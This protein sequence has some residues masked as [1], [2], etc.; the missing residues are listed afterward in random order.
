M[1]RLPALTLIVCTAAAVAAQ[2]PEPAF[3]VASIK[4]NKSGAPSRFLQP[5]PGGR[6]NV[7]NM[8]LRN[9]IAFAYQ[10]RTFQI[11]GGP[12]WQ[13]RIAFDITAKAPGEV[14]APTGAPMTGYTA[15]LR[16]L[17]AER[18][19]LVVRRT[20]KEAPIY[21]LTLAR[22]DGRLGPRLAPSA[23]DCQAVMKEALARG[24]G[25]PPMDPSRFCGA[26]IGVGR[27]ELGGFPIRDLAT[28]LSLALQRTVVDRTG[29]TG[30]FDATVTFAAE[31]LPGVPPMAA[32]QAAPADPD[33]PSLFTALQEQLGLK[34]ES[35]RGPV[36]MLV[37]ERVEMPTED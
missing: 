16:T 8:P 18:F 3:E 12:D 17:L 9:L 37:I 6:L 7:S 35:T 28:S 32:V 2:E 15:M 36:D 5:Q 11:E 13:D 30:N 10:V 25:P 29:L 26:R 21:A 14:A 27:M 34:L 19:K 1:T 4:I 24:G 20:T 23:T 31:A 22:A 33:A